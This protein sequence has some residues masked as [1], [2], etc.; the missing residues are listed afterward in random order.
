MGSKCLVAT[1]IV[2]NGRDDRRIRGDWQT[3]RRRDRYKLHR[4]EVR[5]RD[6]GR[7]R[8]NR[9]AHAV[10]VQLV[11]ASIAPAK[12]MAES[13]QVGRCTAAARAAEA[14]F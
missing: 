7:A 2:A 3:Q 6:F 13:R 10:K 4:T 11:A 9:E 12:S 5:S 8:A 1:I 14:I